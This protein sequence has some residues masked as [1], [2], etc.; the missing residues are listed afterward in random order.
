M[1]T[2]VL[3]RIDDDTE[4]QDLIEDMREWPAPEYA[5]LTPCQENDVHAVLVDVITTKEQPA[6]VE[7]RPLI[8]RCEQCAI[9][10][11]G[12]CTEQATNAPIGY[13]CI[14]LDCHYGVE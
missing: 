6:N 13:P 4:A 9:G 12:E 11:C 2:Y 10:N 5:L 14:C 1:T 8:N 7:E 3:L